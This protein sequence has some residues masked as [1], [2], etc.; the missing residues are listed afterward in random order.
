MAD[1]DLL[2]VVL[3][4]SLKLTAEDIELLQQ[5]SERLRLIAL[6]KSDLPT[7]WNEFGESTNGGSR[8]IEISAKKRRSAL[9]IYGQ[10]LLIRSIR[11]TQMKWAC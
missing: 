2:L 11:L 8:V 10:R 9:G 5:T 1:A 4:G 6:N 7:F 3:D